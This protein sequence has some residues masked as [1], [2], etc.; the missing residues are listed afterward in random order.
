M[1]WSNTP[2]P[3]TLCTTGM[4]TRA[5]TSSSELPQVSQNFLNYSRTFSKLADLSQSIHRT[6]ELVSYLGLHTYTGVSAVEVNLIVILEFD[7]ES[8][9]VRVLK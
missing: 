8:V 7:H 1:E 5:I 6:F 9:E 4:G 3:G 2:R